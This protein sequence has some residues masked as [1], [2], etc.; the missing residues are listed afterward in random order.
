MVLGE[1]AQKEL[2]LVDGVPSVDVD[3]VVYVNDLS[4]C[5]IFENFDE[6]HVSI[7]DWNEIDAKQLLATISENT[8]QAN[9]ER[10]K[11]GF[12]PI[13]VV[14]WIKEPFLDEA[15]NRGVLGARSKR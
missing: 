4:G 3:A 8:E 11:L 9:Q 15:T 5:V 12:A 10:V 7:D 13:H 2:C 1:D 6:G 14:G